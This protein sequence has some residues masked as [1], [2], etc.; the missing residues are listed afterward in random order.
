MDED[1]DTSLPG[2]GGVTSSDE[3]IYNKDLGDIILVDYS[4]II[5][6]SDYIELTDLKYEI[7]TG[8]QFIVSA[9]NEQFIIINE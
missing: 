5:N 2:F 4:N 3:L 8:Q 9:E 1:T 7:I 6:V